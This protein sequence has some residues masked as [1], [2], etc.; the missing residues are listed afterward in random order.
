[1][2]DVPVRSVARAIDVLLS[3]TEGPQ[4]LS[5]ISSTTGLPKAT[6]HRLLASLGHRH[7][8]HQ[9]NDSGSYALGPGC[10]SIVGAATRGWTGLGIGARE[11]LEELQQQSGET[12]TVH[13]A[14]R[15]QRVCVL[16]LSSL[17]PVKYTVGVGHSAP[18][19]VGAAGKVLLAFMDPGERERLM[20]E[21][22][23]ERITD[24]TIT[25]PRSLESELEVIRQRGFGKSSGERVSG[26][27]AISAPVLDDTGRG[28]AVLSVL[29]PDARL[30]E[31][32]LDAL[33]R[34]VT[35]AAQTIS[36]SLGYRSDGTSDTAG[37]A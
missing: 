5:R 24:Q 2:S 21:L 3:L 33:A 18:L 9:D 22:P 35:A 11:T 29:G 1:M 4:P 31:P 32:K 13:V 15:T 8:V 7:L 36:L 23:F 19:H 17:H 12:I 14:V 34:P 37:G 30:P 28:V 10:L 25:N 20:G 16:E 26:A 27:S 6:V